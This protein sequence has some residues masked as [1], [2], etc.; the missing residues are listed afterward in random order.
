MQT[1]QSPTA[2]VDKAAIKR[3]IERLDAPADIKVLLEKLLD[4]TLVIGGKIIQVGSKILD[5]IF[6][7]ARA[8]P[9]IA[10]GVAAALVIS[11]LVHSIPVLGPILSPFLTPV[12]LILGIGL[13]ALNDMMDLSMR[14]RMA[15]VEAQLR[16]F[17]MQ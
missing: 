8:Y 2:L 13:G 3:R 10:L 9:H 6:D 17:G 14:A 16:S 15:G 5:V 4:A 11:Y 12:L 1:P 7:F